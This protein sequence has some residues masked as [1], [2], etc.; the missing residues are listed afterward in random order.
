[1]RCGSG[2]F[3]YYQYQ[4]EE[5]LQA[6]PPAVERG[7]HASARSRR[8]FGDN[9][10]SKTTVAMVNEVLCEAALPQHLTCVILSQCELGIEVEFWKNDDAAAKPD[11]GP[12]VLPM[13][14]PG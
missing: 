7:K 5:F 2:L 14:R 11:A 6:L 9:V 3:H 1:M 13:N 10:R 8:K 4:R 12:D